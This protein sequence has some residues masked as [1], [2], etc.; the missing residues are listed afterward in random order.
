L[1]SEVQRK[2]H[3]IHPCNTERKN[4]LLNFI[5]SQYPEKKILVVTAKDPKSI[6]ITHSKNIIITADAD[7][8]QS[9]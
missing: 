6:E 1:S 9:E 4:E 2:N 5:I 8:G 7:I 3:R